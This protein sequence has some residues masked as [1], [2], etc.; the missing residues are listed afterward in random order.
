MEACPRLVG[1]TEAP[2]GFGACGLGAESLAGQLRGSQL[3]VQ[4]DLLVDLGVGEVVATQGQPEETVDAGPDVG[5]M[6]KCHERVP[7]QTGS[8]TVGTGAVRMPVTIS[9]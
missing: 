4:P 8:D 1:W 9:A 6:G 2:L 3:E 5:M 7:P